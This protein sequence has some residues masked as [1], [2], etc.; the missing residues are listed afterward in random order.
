M[1]M[2]LPVAGSNGRSS[3]T[4]QTGVMRLEIH[5][6][7]SSSRTEVGGRHDGALLVRVAAPADRGA[8]TEAALHAVADA[9]GLARRSVTLVRGARSRRKLI[10]IDVEETGRRSLE[11]R[12]AT[13]ADD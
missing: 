3:Y 10:E 1:E 2:G 12:V 13:L 9:L 4:V 8:A 11:E 7:P 6:R 5:V